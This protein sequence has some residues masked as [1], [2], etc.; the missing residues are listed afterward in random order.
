MMNRA[1]ALTGGQIPT[2]R[3]YGKIVD[4]TN[5]GVEAASITLVTNRMDT[6]TK[7]T[8]EFIAS[9]MLTSKTGGF[10]LENI[11]LFA[12]YTLRI[13]GIGFK[14]VEKRKPPV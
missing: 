4:A 1:A 3:F 14:T 7:Q 5:K 11:A 10:S 12:K 13:T 9:G 6:A 2:G 8:K